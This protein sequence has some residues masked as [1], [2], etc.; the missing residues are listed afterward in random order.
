MSLNLMA[1][2]RYRSVKE[3]IEILLQLDMKPQ[4]YAD[5]LT[6]E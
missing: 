4:T 1:L 6:G 5:L 3:N 2:D